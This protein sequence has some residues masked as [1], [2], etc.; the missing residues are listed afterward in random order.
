MGQGD[1]L[2]HPDV[3][4]AY[5][6]PAP[7]DEDADVDGGVVEGSVGGAAQVPP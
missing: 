6:G 3:D 5:E 2:M 1:A 4:D 7:D